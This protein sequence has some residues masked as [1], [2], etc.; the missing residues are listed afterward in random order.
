MC[1]QEKEKLNYVEIKLMWPNQ[2]GKSK[3]NLDNWKK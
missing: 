3:S 1:F 2:L